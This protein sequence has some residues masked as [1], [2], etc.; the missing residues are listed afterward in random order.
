MGEG[1]G[2]DA[3]YNCSASS[4]Q[5]QQR[6]NAITG[7]YNSSLVLSSTGNNYTRVGD[8]TVRFKV[9]DPT[10][11]IVEATPLLVHVTN[12]ARPAKI[13]MLT[14]RAG[15]V[16]KTGQLFSVQWNNDAITTTKVNVSILDAENRRLGKALF[17]G[18]IVNDGS[19]N[20]VVT[21]FTREDLF[22]Y[23]T[24]QYVSGSGKYIIVV[25]CI[26]GS[27]CEQGESG[28]FTI[29]PTDTTPS[30]SNISQITVMSP[31][32]EENWRIGSTQTI[33]WNGGQNPLEIML[34][35][36][37]EGELVVSG[38]VSTKVDPVTGQYIW[39]VGDIY[40]T[41]SSGKKFF[42]TAT[43][44]KYFIRV[45]DFRTGSLDRS[46]NLF[47]ISAKLPTPSPVNNHIINQPTKSPVIN[48]T[49]APIQDTVIDST[50]INADVSV[51]K[52]DTGM[53]NAIKNIWKRLLSIF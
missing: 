48:N 21:P 44:A 50:Q 31:N 3:G 35:T 39:K 7:V 11:V 51:E 43:P 16:L 41:D 33:K 23:Q 38:W 53:F 24:R 42:S 37:S 45:N 47:T 22:D 4:L 40:N 1:S 32:G 49:V 13:T 20:W 12:D 2:Y 46:D 27:P 10:G 19:E 28:Q 30:P 8:Y 29:M 18:S 36:Y 26:G 15:Q 9:I 25:Q 14:P 34:E 6:Q 5:L 52:Q 17:G